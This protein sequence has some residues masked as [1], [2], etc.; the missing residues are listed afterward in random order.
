M[1]SWVQVHISVQVSLRTVLIL[2]GSFL[3]GGGGFKEWGVKHTESPL[4]I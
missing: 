1:G 4:G 3:S 2:L